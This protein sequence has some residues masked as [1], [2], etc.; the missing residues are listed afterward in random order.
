MNATRR[1]PRDRN[2]EAKLSDGDHSDDGSTPADDRRLTLK[3]RHRIRTLLA[4][5]GEKDEASLPTHQT[6]WSRLYAKVFSTSIGQGE[7][8]VLAADLRGRMERFSHRNICDSEHA[9]A[10]RDRTG[11]F[12]NKH[13]FRHFDRWGAFGS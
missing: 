10:L 9:E 11:A 8:R 13:G 1:R 4:R 2:L 6:E 5:C 12:R 7:D 3:E